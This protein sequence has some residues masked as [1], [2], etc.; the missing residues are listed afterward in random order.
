MPFPLSPPPSQH[1]IERLLGSLAGVVSARVLLDYEGRIR[2]LHVLATP[3]LHPKQVVRNVESALSAGLGV[4]VDRRV[5]SVAQIEGDQERSKP[6]EAKPVAE[7]AP[8]VEAG[9]VVLVDF[10][11]TRASAQRARCTV[12]LERG[13]TRYSG[14][15]EGADTM[16]GRAEAAAEAVLRAVVGMPGG[17]SLGFEGARVVEAEGRSYVLVAVRVMDVRPPLPL[18]GAALMDRAPEEAAIMAALQATN[19]WSTGER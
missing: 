18:S 2:E 8:S 1:Q 9:R 14:A 19:R 11:C 17:A 12:T 6:D 15:A 3:D 16:Q 5:V 10:D 7:P 13:G 4:E